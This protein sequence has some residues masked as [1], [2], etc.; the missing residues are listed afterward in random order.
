MA[1]Y[2]LIIR[3]TGGPEVIEREELGPLTPGPGEVLVRHQAIGLNFIDTY[4]RSG[5]Y[6]L[7]LPSGLGSE[8]AG[9]VE[10]AGEGS[11]FREGERVAYALGPPGAY[12]THRLVAADRLV[13]LPDDVDAE[14]AAAV[15][16]KGCTAEMLVERC[17]KVQAGDW[18]LVHAA[19]GGVG[20]LLVPWLKAVGA[21]VIAHAGSAEKAEIADALGADHSL[22]CPFEELAD[23]V[24]AL[25]GGAGVRS[26]LDGVGAAS[27]AA[28]LASLGRR[29]L[30]VTY[31]NASGPV[32]PFSPLEL[33][34][35]G[36]LF[37][38]RPTL[39]DYVATRAELE[40]S[41]ARLFEM[42]RSGAIQVQIGARFPLAHAAE[43]HRALEARKTTGSTLLIP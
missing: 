26:V 19:A 14:T 16:L 42:L 43:A 15:M 6:P 13:R 5:L 32:P 27:W 8:A 33:S 4:Y 40:A 23:Q 37:V 29:G 7:S 34:R 30:M 10:A 35:R 11:G 25:T 1:P 28:S 2:R 17:A 9:V 41:A 21:K 38:T 20:S 3:K 22:H 39:G 12:A 31:G 36:S 18:V 24:R